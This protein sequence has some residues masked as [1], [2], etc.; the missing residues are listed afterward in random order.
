[1]ASKLKFLQLLDLERKDQALYDAQESA[2]KRIN[3]QDLDE[4]ERTH[5]DYD[6]ESFDD[7]GEDDD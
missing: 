6:S 5:T 4:P 7:G 1:M 3:A 2:R